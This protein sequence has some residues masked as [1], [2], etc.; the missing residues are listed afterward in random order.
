MQKLP[1]IQGLWIGDKLSTMERLCI[2]SFLQ[3][4][5]IFHLYTYDYVKKVPD[6][7]VV[8]DANKIISSDRIF[9][10][11]KHNSYAGFANL[12]RYK[13]LFDK[14]G[15]WVDVDNVCLKPFVSD[16]DYIFA[17]Q[18]LKESPSDA[19]TSAN[20]CLMKAPKGSKI[21]E[22]CY[23]EANS[24]DVNNLK[25]GETGP[26]LL[27]SAIKKFGMEY[28]IAKP[29][30]FCSINF[31]EWNKFIDGTIDE[32]ILQDA[33]SIHL[34]NEMWRRSEV[35]KESQFDKNCLYE[36]FKK[37]YLSIT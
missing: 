21:M 5:H 11:K 12:F 2:S 27:D 32:K 10:Y 34:W 1:I 6:G 36:Y 13:L 35:D 14:G 33:Q 25:W 22:Y 17:S 4:G 30:V 19:S 28:Y 3:N 20:N 18:R 26:K 7:T 29:N 24:K 8:M 23:K 16:A 15:Y 31:W 9:K 37:T